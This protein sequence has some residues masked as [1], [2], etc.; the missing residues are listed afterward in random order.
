MCNIHTI[1]MYQIQNTYLCKV[2][3]AEDSI[4]V[5]FVWLNEG[6]KL[7]STNHLYWKDYQLIH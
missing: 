5:V 4:Q 3:G 6:V 7:Y 2:L 1:Q